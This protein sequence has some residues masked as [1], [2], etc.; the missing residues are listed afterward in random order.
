MGELEPAAEDVAR[1]ETE[2]VEL[3]KPGFGPRLFQQTRR[4]YLCTLIPWLEGLLG[5]EI[6]KGV[7]R[8][9]TGAWPQPSPG[10]DLATVHKAAGRR[11]RDHE[12]P[13]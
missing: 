12:T 7:P 10:Q 1:T 13:A 9:E 11:Q 8:A 4:L 5:Q 2:C 3:C 6:G